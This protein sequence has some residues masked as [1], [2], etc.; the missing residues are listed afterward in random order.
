MLITAEVAIGGSL[1]DGS[2]AEE[3]PK[4]NPSRSPEDVDV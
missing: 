2:D 3:P 4:L 1:A